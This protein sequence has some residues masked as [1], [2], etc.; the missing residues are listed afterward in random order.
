M[1]R[2]ELSRKLGL[3]VNA[4]VRRGPLAGSYAAAVAVCGLARHRRAG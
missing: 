4:R 3:K 1:S 2:D